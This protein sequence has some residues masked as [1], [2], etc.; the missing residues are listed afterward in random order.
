MDVSVP[1]LSETC[2]DTSESGSVKRSVDNGKILVSVIILEK[3]FIGNSVDE[4]IYGIITNP[5]NLAAL[6]PIVEGDTLYAREDVDI[7]YCFL[8]SLCSFCRNLA[9]IRSVDLITIV[10]GRFVAG[11]YDYTSRAAMVT[12]C[13]LKRRGWHESWI[14]IYL[15]SVCSKY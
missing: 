2:C 14:H 8:D 10:F 5:L 12:Y 4:C 1:I 11:C 3:R 7:I 13:N 15:Y 9:A 6:K